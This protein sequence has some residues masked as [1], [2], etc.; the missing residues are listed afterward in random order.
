MPDSRYKP[1]LGFG[2]VTEKFNIGKWNKLY[3]IIRMDSEPTVYELPISADNTG[4]IEI[5]GYI[6]SG[7]FYEVWLLM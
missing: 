4:Y 2:L 6:A 3:E 5:S 7:Y 1:S